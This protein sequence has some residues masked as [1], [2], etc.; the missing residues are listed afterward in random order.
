MGRIRIRLGGRLKA[1]GEGRIWPYS[2]GRLSPEDE[3]EQ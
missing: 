2:D 3:R 1:G